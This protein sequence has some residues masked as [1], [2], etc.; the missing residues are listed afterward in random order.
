MSPRPPKTASPWKVAVLTGSLTNTPFRVAM[1]DAIYSKMEAEG[2]DLNVF[3]ADMDATKQ[4]T[5]FETAL[6]MEPDVIVYWCRRLP[7]RR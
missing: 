3:D 6:M 1:A 4:S 2:W 5:Q 7:R